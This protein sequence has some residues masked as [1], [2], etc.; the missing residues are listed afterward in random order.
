MRGDRLGKVVDGGAEETR[1]LIY[2]QAC[3]PNVHGFYKFGGWAASAAYISDLVSFIFQNHSQVVVECGSGL[4]TLYAAAALK[5]TGGNLLVLE[6]DQRFLAQTKR[7]L[8]RNSLLDHVTI[9]LAPLKEQKILG[10]NCVWYSLDHAILEKSADLIVID[11][12]PQALSELSRYGAASIIERSAPHCGIL[13]DD[14]DTDEMNSVLAA[15]RSV[16]LK[17]R[18]YHPTPSLTSYAIYLFD[19]LT[20]AGRNEDG[21]I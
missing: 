6:H 17:F 20:G 21:G 13:V 7:M 10:Q 8:E 4:S 19:G 3:L 16:G 11:G 14:L 15:W 12:P 2:L 18:S 5:V 1:A 9:E